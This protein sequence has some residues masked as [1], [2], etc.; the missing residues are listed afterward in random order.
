MAGIGL[1]S[2]PVRTTAA[3]QMAAGAPML[4]PTATARG[5]AP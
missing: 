5:W 2:P 4:D 3:N 1:F